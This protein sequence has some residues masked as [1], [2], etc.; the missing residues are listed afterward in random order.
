MTIATHGLAGTEGRPRSLLP[1]HRK[2]L[3]L[4]AAELPRVPQAASPEPKSKHGAD[5]PG[6]VD[7][8]KSGSDAR[9]VSV[10]PPLSGYCCQSS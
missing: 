5:Q 9:L 10:A 6:R 7:T 3:L 8:S 1:G 2:R 4:A